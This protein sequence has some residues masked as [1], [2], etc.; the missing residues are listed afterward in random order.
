MEDKVYSKTEFDDI[1]N[2]L[3]NEILR[4]G[5][6]KWWDPLTYPAVGTER[7]S[8]ITDKTYTINNP[9][10][11]SLE[12]T[13]N[14][15][16][17]NQGDNPSED[18][19]KSSTRFDVDEI[20]NFL[21]GLSKM[22]DIDQFYGRDEQ[23]GTMY[24]DPKDIE[25]KL[26]MAE[27]DELHVPRTENMQKYDPNGG[28]TNKQYESYGLYPDGNTNVQVTVPPSYRSGEY[29][30]EE[31][32][33]GYDMPDETNFYDDFGAQSGTYEVYDVPG[34]AK[35]R[36]IT[37]VEEA[38]I[39][40][41]KTKT[42]IN[43]AADRS[44]HFRS[45]YTASDIHHHPQN[46]YQSEVKNRTNIDQN[47]DR[48]EVI[49]EKTFG[50]TSSERFGLNP[51]NPNMY[52]SDNPPLS[53]DTL[54]VSNYPNKFGTG[55]PAVFNKRF[56]FRAKEYENS[57]QTFQG[58]D[59]LCHVACTGLCH[60]S[61][62]NECSE[63]CSSTCWNRCGNA[64]YA[65]CGNVCTGCNT[66]CYQ[67]CDTRCQDNGGLS[68]YKAGAETVRI[69]ATGRK[70][71]CSNNCGINCT[72]QSY[73]TGSYGRN[74]CAGSCV[75]T[76]INQSTFK[77]SLNIQN[78]VESSFYTCKGCSYTCEHYP[79]MR[80]TCWDNLCETLC[81]TTCVNYCATTCYGGCVGNPNEHQGDNNHRKYNDQ[82]KYVNG[83]GQ[84]CMNACT[85][86]CVG[87]CTNSC[88]ANGCKSV[89]YNNCNTSCHS[90][91]I[92]NCQTHCSSNCSF[93]CV[94]STSGGQ[95]TD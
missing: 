62:D 71:S 47:K 63:H 37:L 28:L 59:G 61:C 45:E 22:H 5:S 43:V 2:R 50:G 21:L 51:R 48:S 74:D 60:T 34:T 38:G 15:T 94:G 58:D 65:S 35:T 73:H 31:I 12:E 27:S 90:K 3:N 17:P 32:L 80:T 55:D 1:R 9:S 8:L 42:T 92:N 79:N 93:N 44:D 68:C 52:Q 36:D 91:C 88:I 23:S 46:P 77:N 13:R 40:A 86:D 66:L 49:T 29:D 75:M 39:Y 84:G 11:G 6:F 57:R 33:P 69:F 70:T 20:K 30:G 83:I 4:R 72:G 54:P 87:N 53:Q 7:D 19:F 16:H 41:G 24:R 26:S 85:A 78:K 76:C 10:S 56:L 81:F 64:C 82:S 67:T 95:Q 14:I 18:S 89:C 25:H